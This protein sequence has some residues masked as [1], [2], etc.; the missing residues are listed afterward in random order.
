MADNTANFQLG[1]CTISVDGTEVGYTT[2]D[3][4]SV[5]ITGELKDVRPS[6]ASAPAEA[7]SSIEGIEITGKMLQTAEQATLL[8]YI[9]PSAT[10]SGDQVKFGR[11][12]GYRASAN[13]ASI[14]LHP[15]DQDAV[16]TQDITIYRGLFDNSTEIEYGDEGE[17]SYAFKIK[18]YFDDSRTDGDRLFSFGSSADSTPPGRTSTAPADG[19]AAQ[20][21]T[22]NIVI[23]FDESMSVRTLVDDDGHSPVI[24]YD[25][26][27]EA[28]VACAA[29][30]STTTNENDTLTLN[31]D[32]SLTASATINV[33]VPEKC[34]DRAGNAHAG[35][36]TDFA[37][38]A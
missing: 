3:G 1:A 22:T 8:G 10:V 25:S 30:V 32:A 23:V 26:T 6:R 13:V 24:I 4:I 19:A 34:K 18:G 35:T 33:L 16:T 27:N 31:P 11:E 9:L 12:P 28:V 38:A 21:A 36:Q 5:S 2:E 15:V 17:R 20:L 37:V 14:V 29:T 7:F